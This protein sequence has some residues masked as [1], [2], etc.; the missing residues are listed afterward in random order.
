MAKRKKKA[1]CCNSNAAQNWLPSKKCHTTHLD[2]ALPDTTNMTSQQENQAQE[3]FDKLCK[4]TGSDEEENTETK[5]QSPY[6]QLMLI[7]S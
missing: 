5:F 3:L 7:V 2:N 1:K 6:F 4:A